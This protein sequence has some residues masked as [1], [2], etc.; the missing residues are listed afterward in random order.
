MTNLYAPPSRRWL[1]SAAGVVLLAG[2]LPATAQAAPAAPAPQPAN[3]TAELPNFDAR[4]LTPARTGTA[5]AKRALAADKAGSPARDL[6]AALGVQGVVEIDR[7]TGTPRQVAKLDGFLTAASKAAPEKIARDY[8]AAHSD[9]FGLTSG[10]NAGLK[11]RKDYVDIA[12]THHLSFTQSVGGVEVFGNGV[13]A[14]IAKDGRLVSVDGSPLAG[15]PA[16]VGDAKLDATAA[17]K[18]AVRDVFGDSTATVKSAAAG[19]TKFS[20]GGNARQVVF[21]TA[22]PRLA[23]QV[24]SMDEGYLSVVD[25]ADSKVLF[26]QNIV[27]NDHAQTWENYPGAPS[28]GTQHTVNLNKWLPVD[29]PKLEGN[30]AHVFSDVNDDDTAQATEEVLPAAKRSFDFPFTDFSAQVGGRCSAQYKCSWNPAVPNSWQTNRSQ[31]ATQMYWFLGNWHDHLAAAPIGFTR[32][33]GNFEA[34]DGDAVVG[35]ALDGANTANGLPDAD[36]DDNAN[37][38][39]PADGTSPRMQMYLTLPT[40]TRIASNTGDEADVV[41]H[42]YTHG[43]SNRLVVDATGN[44]TLNSQQAGAMGEA[45]SDWYAMDYLASQGLLPDTATDGELKVGVYWSSGGSIRTEATDCSLN[46]TVAAC[47]GTPAAGKGGYT[48]GDYG[49]IRPSGVPEVHADGEIWAQTLWDL[50]KVIG[51]QKARSLVTRAMELAPADPTFLDMRNSILQADL[52]VNDGKLQKKIWT[53]FADRGMGYFAGALNAADTSPVEDFSLPPNPNSPRGSLTG[54]VTDQ[55][56]SR[57]APGVTVAFG[58]H[59]SGFA[60]DYAAVTAA[61]GTYTISGIIPGTYPKVFAQGAGYDP[62]SVAA[63]SIRSGAN[64]K[65]WAVRRDWAAASGGATIVSATGP[66]YTS[67]GC[68]PIGLIDQGQGS[69]WGSDV[70]ANGQNAVVKLPA[71]VTISQLVINPSATCGDDATAGTGDFRVETSAD[72]ATWTVAASGRFPLNTV[73]PQVVPVTAGGTNVGYVRFT[74]VNSQAQAAGLCPA[75]VSG[76]TFLDSTELAIYGSPTA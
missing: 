18:A 20:D 63:I 47:A 14:H 61:N 19:T 13:K 8:L 59:A 5:A 31:N 72:G 62:N 66:D 24:T 34:V 60:G 57:P 74:M 37:M 10:D 54:T 22:G 26:R 45:W 11:L 64:R 75:A 2:L 50:R 12:G 53:V 42:E 25:A 23:W 48:Y 36:H 27:A 9:V 69:G 17:R 58:G 67:F 73:T 35:N 16:S 1:A 39:T 46:S 41:Y 7:A 49:R 29:A 52:V 65:D 51:S 76:C 70:A 4:D 6:R 68:G 21:N 30:V 15:L 3:T 43:L 71:A 28:G 44:S 38:A 32:A 40:A 56:T 55:E 33:A